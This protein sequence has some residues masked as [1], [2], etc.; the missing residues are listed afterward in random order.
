MPG[1]VLNQT[2]H[3]CLGS[4][5][6][7][8]SLCSFSG[9]Q[10]R[11]SLKRGARYLVMR[12][13][14]K[15][16]RFLAQAVLFGRGTWRRGSD[17]SWQM[18]AMYAFLELTGFEHADLS[19]AFPGTQLALA[20]YS[21]AKRIGHRHGIWQCWSAGNAFFT[22]PLPELPGCEVMQVFIRKNTGCC[23]LPLG[24]HPLIDGVA[25]Y[26]AEISP[27]AGSGGCIEFCLPERSIISF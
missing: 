3:G 22:N 20:Q 18:M 26:W 23:L 14:G 4:G 2:R 25:S 15:G 7:G 17:N 5:N 12:L 9:H 24:I 1:K 27:P 21:S 8:W 19:Q 10:C 13:V 16:H 6:S 11:K